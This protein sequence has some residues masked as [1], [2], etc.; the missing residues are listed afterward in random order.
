MRSVFADTLYWIAVLNP[1]D[2]WRDPAMLARQ[3]LGRSK[4]VTTDG[5]FAELLAALARSP[6]LRD[7][8]VSSV[9]ASMEAPDVLVIPQTRA[10]F[11]DGLALYEARPDK[12]YSLTDCISMSIMRSSGIADVLTNDEH[13]AQEGFNVLIR[14]I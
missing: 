6:R 13:F 7:L 10:S 2:S 9:R 4:L 12:H 11:L 3:R 14:P 1:R 5:V 8:A